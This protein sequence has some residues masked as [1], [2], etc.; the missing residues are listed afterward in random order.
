M[1]GT[2]VFDPV[3][4][5]PIKSGMRNPPPGDE[6]TAKKYGETAGIIP[7]ES[8]LYNVLGR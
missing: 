8:L 7:V 2:P 1:A 5:L 3:Q 4:R 6:L